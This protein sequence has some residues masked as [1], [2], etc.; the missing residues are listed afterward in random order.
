MQKGKIISIKGQVV[1]VEFLG[2]KP[3]IHDIL[4]LEKDKN[5]C[6]EVHMPLSTNVYYC[7]SITD[8]E[9]LSR[10]QNVVN[11]RESL[12]FPM[13][14]GI[15]GRVLDVFGAPQDEKGELTDVKPVSIYKEKQRL[16][17]V[18]SPKEILTT[19][20][21]VIDFFSPLLRGGK[22]GFFGGAG[23]GKTV[24]LTEIMHNVISENAE[25]NVSVFTGVGERVREG[26]ELFATLTESG[27]IENIT[28]LYGQMGENPAVRFKTAI[29]GIALAE[30][31]RDA[32]SQD[33][34]FFIDNM[35]RF[36]QAG[37]ELSTLVDSM[38]SEGGYQATLMTEMASLHERLVSTRKNSIT[39]FETI[40]VPSDDIT[41]YGVQSIF[42][43]LD[44]TIT[45]SRAIYQEGRFPAIDLLASTS[46]A[47]SPKIV[48]EE[49]YDTLIATQGLLKKAVGLER[50]ASLIGETELAPNDKLF[51]KRAKIIKNYMTQNFF[52]TKAQTG[53]EGSA[54]AIADVVS[55][56]RAILSGNFDTVDE[57]KFKN[58]ATTKD[59]AE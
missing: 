42:P 26:E 19:G 23:V 51:Y 47:L 35:Y 3:F 2:E 14:K 43:Y 13:G 44:A 12:Q 10:G 57:S 33:V 21:K 6:L 18:I 20:I 37:Y 24:L 56:M 52:V 28:L 48:G 49:H 30:Y 45:L 54:V 7:I 50:I 9:I 8:T 40:Y 53:K 38:P 1:E 36:A 39:S 5:V 58:I 31:F 11:T 15:L 22:I 16:K 17:D 46:I 34:L 25:K 59:L 41:D 55:D 27:V 4:T 29:A 32:L